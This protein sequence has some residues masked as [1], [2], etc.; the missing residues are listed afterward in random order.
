MNGTRALFAAVQPAPDPAIRV[1]PDHAYGPHARHKLD[2]FLPPDHSPRRDHPVLVF[3]HGGGFSA[4]D[5]RTAGTPYFQNIGIWAAR[6]GWL[7]VTM[8]YRLA[9]E[10]AWPCG[11]DDVA[12]ACAWLTQHVAHYGGDPQR[13]VLMGH[14]AGAAH[15]A[16][17]IAGAD[18]HTGPAIAGAVLLSGIYH[19][20]V[21]SPTPWLTAY[22]GAN[23]RPD[24]DL[25][26]GLAASPV[27]LLITRSELDPADL[28]EQAELLHQALR[29]AG[30]TDIRCDRL[31]GHNHYSPALHFNAEE[32]VLT[33]YLQDLAGGASP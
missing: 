5:K 12:L 17:C 7:G 15:V 6:H 27:P 22:Y 23:P 18:A 21:M 11:A 25:R 20:A 8:N 32:S 31:E 24:H 1:L 9:P 10:H 4:G 2:L 30:R 14:S 13:I 33:Q 26:P 28:Q 19:H 3:V 29:A 16:A